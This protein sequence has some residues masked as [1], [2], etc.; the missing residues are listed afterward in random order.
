MHCLTHTNPRASASDGRTNGSTDGQTDGRTDEWTGGLPT[1]YGRSSHHGCSGSGRRAVA[2][3]GQKHRKPAALFEIRGV[4]LQIRAGERDGAVIGG[5]G[6]FARIRDPAIGVR[7][8]SPVEVSVGLQG[9]GLL[10]RRGR[11]GVRLKRTFEG[12]E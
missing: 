12:L 1:P 11:L 3:L 6:F 7:E 10:E 9:G 4:V 5:K 8:V 2:A